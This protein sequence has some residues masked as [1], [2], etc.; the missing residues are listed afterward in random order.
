M[1]RD[2]EYGE[3]GW[4]SGGPVEGTAVGWGYVLKVLKKTEREVKL[5]PVLVISV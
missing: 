3:T 4:H 5:R 1:Q 2:P